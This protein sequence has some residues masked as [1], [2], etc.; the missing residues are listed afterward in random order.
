MQESWEE[1]Q[2]GSHTKKSR[3][4]LSAR[5]LDR[6]VTES[7]YLMGIKEIYVLLRAE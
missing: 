5:E 1:T 6:Y 4:I 3:S 7:W 2:L